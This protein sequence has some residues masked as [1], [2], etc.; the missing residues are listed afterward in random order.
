M[1]PPS[2][3][4][5]ASEVKCSA[6]SSSRLRAATRIVARFILFAPC[7]RQ[8]LKPGRGA[9]R[10]GL[11]IQVALFARFR[12]QVAGRRSQVAGRRSQVAGRR[13]QG[14][15]RRV[16]GPGLHVL[17][18]TCRRTISSP[19]GRGILGS[20]SRTSRAEPVD[21]TSSKPEGCS[22]LWAGNVGHSQAIQLEAGLGKTADTISYPAR[23]GTK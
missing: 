16:Q 10:R 13:S 5:A 3:A 15:R 12:S 1:Y 9:F 23:E 17:S 11:P 6:A 8:K 22:L 20:M 18:A 4:R 14:A 2:A 21:V 19:K 7:P